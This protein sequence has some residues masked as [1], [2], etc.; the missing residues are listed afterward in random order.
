MNAFLAAG[1]SVEA[2]YL[3]NSITSAAVIGTTQNQMGWGIY[4]HNSKKVPYFVTGSG[5]TYNAA[6]ATKTISDTELIHV[7]ATYDPMEKVHTI[8]VNGEECSDRA[9]SQPGTNIPGVVAA[10]TTSTDG[11]AMFNTFGM[12][13]DLSS[14]TSSAGDFLATDLTVVDAKIYNKTLT[15]EEVAEA[16]SKAVAEFTE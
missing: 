10:N 3:D 13:G 14:A 6:Y 15:A 7:V 12:G 2:F 4:H 9:T 16:Y 11:I 8:Y 5:K 1:F